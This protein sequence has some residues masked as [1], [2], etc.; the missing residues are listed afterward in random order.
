MSEGGSVCVREKRRVE[1]QNRG[2]GGRGRRAGGDGPQAVHV[3]DH[4]SPYFLLRALFAMN[5]FGVGYPKISN[6]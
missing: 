5:F 2:T 1:V 3:N 6:F 4:N